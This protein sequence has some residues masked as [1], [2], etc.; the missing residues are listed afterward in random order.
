M[1]VL[2]PRHV[3]RPALKSGMNFFEVC[4]CK[5][6]GIEPAYFLQ[7]LVLNLG[8]IAMQFHKRIHRDVV[9]TLY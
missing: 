2:Q 7:K 3:F 8:I 9:M 1:T 6:R 4:L 5:F